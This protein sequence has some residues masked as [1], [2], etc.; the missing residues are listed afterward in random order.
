MKQVDRWQSQNVKCLTQPMSLFVVRVHLKFDVV[1]HAK[2]ELQS[3]Y[4]QLL[5]GCLL[6]LL[7]QHFEQ[8]LMLPT[9]TIPWCTK[10][11]PDFLVSWTSKIPVSFLKIPVSPI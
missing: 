11:P 6:L 8:V 5:R 7:L 9:V 3:G 10:A 2:G 1:Q 4:V